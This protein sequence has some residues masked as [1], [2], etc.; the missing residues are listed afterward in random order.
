MDMNLYVLEVTARHHLSE[1]RAE[2]ARYLLAKAAAP[3]RTPLRVALGL[4][5][6]RLGTWARGDVGREAARAV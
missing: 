1:R 5:L 4:A 6:I 2:A 3:P